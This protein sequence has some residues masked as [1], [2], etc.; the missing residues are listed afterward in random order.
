MLLGILPVACSNDDGPTEPAADDA[1][2]TTKTIGGAGGTIQLTAPD[3]VALAVSLPEGAVLEDVRFRLVALEAAGSART[4]FRLEPA[5]QVFL[6]PVILS[7]D[8][9]PGE[10]ASRWSVFFKTGT[11]ESVRHATVVDN[12]LEVTLWDSGFD[13][14]VDASQA[15]ASRIDGLFT[16]AEL[17]EMEC[18]II[19]ESLNSR[20]DNLGAWMSADGDPTMMVA[21][22]DEVL[23]MILEMKVRCSGELSEDLTQLAEA[24]CA[25][26]NSTLVD[27]SVFVLPASSDLGVVRRYLAP[28]LGAAALSSAL[29]SECAGEAGV[30]VNEILDHILDSYTKGISQPG[31]LA[32][33][34]W[35]RVWNH[36]R[37]ITRL[38]ADAQELGADDVVRR[39]VEQVL[40]AMYGTFRNLAR[41]ACDESGAQACLADLATGGAYSG[42]DPVAYP[43]DDVPSWG[44]VTR[45]SLLDDIQQCGNSVVVEVYDVFGD[46]LS[47]H[48]LGG[49]KLRIEVPSDGSLDFK[50]MLRPLM[51]SLAGGNTS[52]GDDKIV[53]RTGE[54]DLLTRQ[55]ASGNFL[56]PAA[57]LS[58]NELIAAAP[59][60]D[61][62]D[63]SVRRRGSACG[64]W[65]EGNPGGGTMDRTLY[66]L[67]VVPIVTGLRF[68]G[69]G[70]I[71]RCTA[72]HSSPGLWE[73]ERV[74]WPQPLSDGTTS[75]SASKQCDLTW[76]DYLERDHNVSSSA[77]VS[78]TVNVEN[79]DGVPYLASVSMTASVSAAIETST[80]GGAGW[81]RLGFS[82]LAEGGR[83]MVLDWTASDDV[84]VVVDGYD[85]SSPYV[86]SPNRA[87]GVQVTCGMWVSAYAF[88][89]NCT[90]VWESRDSTA[91]YSFR[92]TVLPYRE[93]SGALS[94]WRR[95]LSE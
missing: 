31:A 58:L 34:G 64:G 21:Q 39:I 71:A 26:Y 40:P 86:I 2:V 79:R 51:C 82:V 74:S 68:I 65:Y 6:Q 38:M 41:Q 93:E 75:A 88:G 42:R 83:P 24:A 11:N 9:P 62:I 22:S 15:Q 5:E 33:E 45:E 1:T 70:L 16:E 35:P 59:G 78:G 19:R 25:R 47:E 63:L 53:F 43:V 50:G 66:E 80:G 72:Q 37:D 85:R 4:R 61:V 87:V 8:L 12:Q 89:C 55:A 27:A 52:V 36:L 10:D 91:T 54:T 95:S 32:N 92:A 90:Q 84:S 28:V 49:G 44:G 14:R 94:A 46:L 17:R 3:G 56:S 23:S 20:L 30:E 73:E 81:A 18:Q 7:F 67:E 48:P 29:G 69:G 13:T 77:S 76:T 57:S 60:K